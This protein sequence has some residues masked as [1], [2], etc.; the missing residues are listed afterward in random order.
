LHTGIDKLYDVDTI[1]GMLLRA[2]K[3]H[4]IWL[5][6]M[7]KAD[8]G[9]TILFHGPM[10]SRT[11]GQNSRQGRLEFHTNHDPEGAQGDRIS[12]GGNQLSD[13]ADKNWMEA[14]EIPSDPNSLV[15]SILG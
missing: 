1:R 7:G 2:E 10:R 14:L 12:W 9:Q 11:V 4:E 5:G 6:R 8:L 13:P 3:D 15:H